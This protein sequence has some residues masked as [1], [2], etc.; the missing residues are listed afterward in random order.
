MAGIYTIKDDRPT[1]WLRLVRGPQFVT[2]DGVTVKADKAWMAE[3]IAAF[4]RLTSDGYVPPVITDHNAALTRQRALGDVLDL[5]VEKVDGEDEL[6]A[7]VAWNDP[8]VVEDI[9]AKRLKYVS[10]GFKSFQDER[11]EKFHLVLSELSIT[12]TP[13]RKGAA[14]H[15]LMTEA[16]MPDPILNVDPAALPAPELDAAAPSVDERIASI[17]AAVTDL[18]A[19]FANLQTMLQDMVDEKTEEAPEAPVEALPLAEE[20]AAVVPPVPAAAVPAV[21]EELKMSERELGLAQRLQETEVALAVAQ[22]AQRRASFDL[23]YPAGSI[24]EMS[25]A[26][27]DLFFTLSEAAP[28]AVHALTIQAVKPS[29]ASGPVG[30]PHRSSVPWNIA[31]GESTHTAAPVEEDDNA[32]MTRLINENGGSPSKGLAAFKHLRP[33]R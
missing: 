11:G 30:P 21:P 12:A 5:V 8:T 23:R 14:T 16:V 28:D 4:K 29:E 20:P 2:P 9:A 15:I 24:I 31:M 10:P 26:Q 7:G 3:R 13:H 33:G 19:S 27:R 1:N 25:E 22:K 18:T 17:E 6:V 32:L